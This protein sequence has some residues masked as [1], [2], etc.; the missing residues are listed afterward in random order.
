MPPNLNSTSSIQL[1][2]AF[3]NAM[4]LQVETKLSLFQDSMASFHATFLS[5]NAACERLIVTPYRLRIYS[6]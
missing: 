1:Q 3:I 6:I 2:K 5:K 4:Y